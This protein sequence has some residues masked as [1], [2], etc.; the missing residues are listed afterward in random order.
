MVRPLLAEITPFVAK[1]LA[2][3]GNPAPKHL[4]AR[5]SV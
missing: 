5:G 1:P 3:V 2:R 4:G